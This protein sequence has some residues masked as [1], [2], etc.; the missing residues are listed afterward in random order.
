[1]SR[2]KLTTR[3]A[4][5]SDLDFVGQ[6]HSLLPAI[7]RRKIQW[8]EIIVAE[9]ND[10]LAGYLRLEYLWSKVPYLALI[11]VLPE[12]RGQGVGKALLTFTEEFLRAEGQ[13]TLYSSSQA[14]E[15]E[16]Q[17]WH[18]QSGFEECGMIAGVNEGGIGEVF[19]RK[20]L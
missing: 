7:V 11:R 8:R 15:A 18:R 6:D 9:F 1:M 14:N 2:G 13:T 19:F 16:A 17:A 10:D 5:A 4:L 12:Y 20:E 3:F